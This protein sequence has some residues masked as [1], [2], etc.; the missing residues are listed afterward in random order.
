VIQ[1]PIMGPRLVME[2]T[3]REKDFLIAGE[4][5]SKTKKAL[6]QLGLR[7]DVVRNAA[8][9]VYEAAMDTTDALRS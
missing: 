9:I 3:I 1:S 2:F 6:Q 5:A 8:I 4:S 7:T